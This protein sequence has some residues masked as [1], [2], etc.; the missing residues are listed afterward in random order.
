MTWE[1]S[2]RSLLKDSCNCC[3]FVFPLLSLSVPL[4]FAQSML[5]TP[6]TYKLMS[7]LR[8]ALGSLGWHRPEN[9]EI[10]LVCEPSFQRHSDLRVV[11]DVGDKHSLSF[12]FR[13]FLLGLLGAVK[14]TLKLLTFHR[15]YTEKGDVRISILGT[16]PKLCCCFPL[17]FLN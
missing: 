7:S 3:S 6:Q 4:V 16:F 11:C 1:T 17:Y 15:Q 8:R 5:L 10:R 14:L 9:Q 2:Q 13:C 12:H